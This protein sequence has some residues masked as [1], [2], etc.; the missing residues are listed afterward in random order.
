MINTNANLQVATI[1]VTILG[2]FIKQNPYSSLVPRVHM[3]YGV[4]ISQ[5]IPFAR[6]CSNVDDF[7]NSRAL[8]NAELW[9][10]VRIFFPWDT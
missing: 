4:H 2:D 3:V 7:N 1:L 6:V 9:V 10:L 5:L 8:G